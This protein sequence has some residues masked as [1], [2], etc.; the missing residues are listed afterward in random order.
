MALAFA[1]LA[2]GIA[3]VHRQTEAERDRGK[4]LLVEVSDVFVRQ[5]HN[6][7]DLPLVN[8]YVAQER[9]RCGDRDGAIPQMGAAA[10]HLAREGQLLGWGT[11]ATGVLVETLL[12]RAAESDSAADLTEAEAAIERLA[13][14]STDEGLVMREVWLLRLRAL[15]ARAHGD[16]AAYVH[17]RDRYREMA[18]TLGFAGHMNWAEAMK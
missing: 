8:V 12:D 10:D 18:K 3:L 11:P 15:L 1:R 2:L 14:A 4:A 13:A 17:F 16:T 7:G 9:A 6:L 5:R